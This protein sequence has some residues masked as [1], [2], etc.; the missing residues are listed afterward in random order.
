MK[1]IRILAIVTMIIGIF[2]VFAFLLNWMALTDIWHGEQNVRLEWQI[3]SFAQL[4]MFVFHLLAIGL[5][6]SIFGYLKNREQIVS[7]E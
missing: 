3:V 1:R 7:S 6:I 4:P 5:S 2:S